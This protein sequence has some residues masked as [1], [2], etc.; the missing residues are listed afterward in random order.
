MSQERITR[1]RETILSDLLSAKAGFERALQPESPNVFTWHGEE[2]WVDRVRRFVIPGACASRVKE[3][4]WTSKDTLP[5]NDFE[6]SELLDIYCGEYQLEDSGSIERMWARLI[7]GVASRHAWA[8]EGAKVI[9][10]AVAQLS[11]NPA[12]GPLFWLALA[13][14][15]GPI[16]DHRDNLFKLVL[17]MIYL[18]IHYPQRVPSPEEVRRAQIDF[19]ERVFP[20]STDGGC[21]QLS[22]GDWAAHCDEQLRLHQQLVDDRVFEPLLERIGALDEPEARPF[23]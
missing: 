13:D 12:F 23:S 14:D 3:D 4:A 1:L 22:D 9:N 6:A 17:P 15:L 10:L 8:M 20:G 5:A 18:Q 16:G 2:F 11:I 21:E 19:L 7:G